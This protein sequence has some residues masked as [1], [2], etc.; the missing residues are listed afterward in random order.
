MTNLYLAHPILDRKRIRR[1]ETELEKDLGIE[2][3]NPFYDTAERTDILKLDSGR[4]KPFSR[5]FN[6]KKIVEGDLKLIR[7]ADGLLGII[8]KKTTV[9]TLMEIFYAGVVLKKPVYLVIEK[10]K[11]RGHPWL[12]YCADEIFPNFEEA[13]RF[14]R[15]KLK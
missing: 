7:A 8:G 6:E 1:I 15:K 2:L 5:R 3:I 11:L 13:K 14:L 10:K 4:I 12:R 9:G